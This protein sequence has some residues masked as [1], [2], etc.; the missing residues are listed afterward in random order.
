MRNKINPFYAITPL[1]VILTFMS[2]AWAEEQKLGNVS[3]KYTRETENESATLEVNLLSDGKVRIK[4]MSLWGR[5]RKYG[6][7]IG[8]LDFKASIKNGRVEYTE[9]IGKR[10]HY[11]LELTFVEGGLS[12][13]EEGISAH[14]G[15]N[16]K[17]AGKY[18]KK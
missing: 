7:N 16:V 9:G 17:F 12:A 6:P 3:G 13:K 10:Q 11:K 14:F 8:E 2:G 5:N 4:G 1:V 15:L 18:K